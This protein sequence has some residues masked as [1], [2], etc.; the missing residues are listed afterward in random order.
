MIKITRMSL[1]SGKEHTLD[2][3]VTLEEIKKWES[4]VLAQ[5]AFP[6]LTPAERE[7]IISGITPEEWDALFAGT[8]EEE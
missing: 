1:V 6:R 3:D 8:D 2:L 5:N 7:F 4:G